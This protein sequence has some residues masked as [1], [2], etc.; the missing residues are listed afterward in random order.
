MPR[1]RCLR[2]T[3][4]G[5]HPHACIAAASTT[6]LVCTDNNT[7][8]QTDAHRHRYT[9]TQTQS[10]AA[11]AA[12]G[13]THELRMPAR[14]SSTSCSSHPESPPISPPPPP[15][16]SSSERAVLP[17]SDVSRTDATRSP[18]AVSSS[19]SLRLPVPLP[20][21]PPHTDPSHTPCLFDTHGTSRTRFL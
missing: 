21:L 20:L 7:D 12:A 1:P 5:S 10:D 18:S 11:A 4:A 13:E 3:S 19:L 16:S 9:D 15:P 2:T 17:W 8:T 6:R 14:Q